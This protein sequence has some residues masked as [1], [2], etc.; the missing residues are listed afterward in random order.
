MA[1]FG[2]LFDGLQQALGCIEPAFIDRSLVQ[3]E[4][5]AGKGNVL[6]IADAHVVRRH[7]RKAK[8]FPW[9]RV[10]AMMQRWS[11]GYRS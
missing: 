10:N 3:L 1:A 2:K 5:L 8:A 9:G 6:L 4:Q 11:R 7:A